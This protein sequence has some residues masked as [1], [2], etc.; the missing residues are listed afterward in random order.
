MTH[1]RGEPLPPS[2]KQARSTTG[3]GSPRTIASPRTKEGDP[4][5]GWTG[6]GLIVS[7]TCVRGNAK[8]LFKTEHS[9]TRPDPWTAMGTPRNNLASANPFFFRQGPAGH[10]PARLIARN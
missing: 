4:G 3:I 6:N 9:N 1:R 7:S 10:G 8:E 2:I 5:I